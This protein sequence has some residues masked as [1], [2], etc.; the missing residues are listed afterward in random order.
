MKFLLRL[1]I[2]L[3]LRDQVKICLGGATLYD[4]FY[5]CALRQ[6]KAILNSIAVSLC[7]VPEDLVIGE[8]PA[9]FN[10]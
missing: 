6:M 2:K 10:L 3:T 4:F 8:T 7:L 5:Q 9:G 1:D